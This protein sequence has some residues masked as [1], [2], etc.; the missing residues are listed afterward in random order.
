MLSKAAK[1][2]IADNRRAR[3]L[4][5]KVS[6]V[7]RNFYNA[8]VLPASAFAPGFPAGK[9]IFLS[10]YAIGIFAAEP[11][12]SADI[13]RGVFIRNQRDESAAFTISKSQRLLRYDE[14]G[15]EIDLVA[16]LKEDEAK[17]PQR[18]LTC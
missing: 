2:R 16:R 4:K 18:G 11:G 7:R 17:P 8:L 15:R 1:A 9:R 3:D 10:K 5:L 12:D 6:F 13:I 14:S